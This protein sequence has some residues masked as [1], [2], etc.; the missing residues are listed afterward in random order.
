VIHPD[1]LPTGL[2]NTDPLREWADKMHDGWTLT[3]YSVI[4]DPFG[5]VL[6]GPLVNE[7][8]IL[9]A[10]LDFDLTE[11]RKRMFDAAGHYSRP[12]VFRLEVDDR[13]KPPVITTSDTAE[14][15]GIH[16]T[17]E[18]PAQAWSTGSAHVPVDGDAR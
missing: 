1:W 4:V 7:R 9:L 16:V 12:D 18:E 17:T 10:E 14:A 15:P 11:A 5:K 13:P 2:P 3:G 6:A 8:G